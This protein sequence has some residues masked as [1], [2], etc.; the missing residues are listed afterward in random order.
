MGNVPEALPM[1]SY[2]Q[3]IKDNTEIGPFLRLL[4]VRALRIDRTK[5]CIRDF[6]KNTPQMGP[7]YT[8]PVTDTVESVHQTMDC[9]TPVIFFLSVGEDPTDAV[10]SLA[11]KRKT[12]VDCISMGE[13][14]A[15]PAIA[16]I[17]NAWSAGT[18][19][20]LQNCELGLDLM[21][22]MEQMILKSS[23][24][25]NFRLMFS[26]NPHPQFPLG[27]LQMCTKMT[28]EPPQ[29]L[30][31]GLLRSLNTMID[32]DLLERIE[33]SHW[34]RLVNTLCFLHSIVHERKTSTRF[35]TGKLPAAHQSHGWPRHPAQHFPVPGDPARPGCPYY[36]AHNT[37]VP[38]PGHQRRSRH[39]G[40]A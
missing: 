1:P 30:R 11:K 21:V 36:G 31:A 14:Q 25:E 6:V 27:L 24:S 40:R 19:V 3:Q 20:L 10:E 28:N 2:D 16:A 26:A 38:A 18:W 5:L 39:D 34:R 22:D 37:G 15:V 8:E 29:G 7:K 4:L 9:M 32:Q 33:S 35:H 13:G 23:P 12:Q 17:K